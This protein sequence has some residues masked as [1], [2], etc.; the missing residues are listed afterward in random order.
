MIYDFCGMRN[1]IADKCME[2]GPAF[3]PPNICQRV[4]KYNA[5]HYPITKVVTLYWKPNPPI[6]QHFHQNA[7]RPEITDINCNESR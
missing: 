1:Y 6:S 2:H 3:Q 7:S 5:K 4:S